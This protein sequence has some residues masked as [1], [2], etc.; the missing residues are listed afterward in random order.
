MRLDRP[1]SFS[2]SRFITLQMLMKSQR[3]CTAD[4]LL[5]D[6]NWRQF[7]CGVRG[8]NGK[9]QQVEVLVAKTNHTAYRRA[10]PVALAGSVCCG[11]L[12]LNNPNIGRA[13]VGETSKAAPPIR[14]CSG[15]VALLAVHRLTPHLP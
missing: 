13:R 11:L 9:H 7:P 2:S 8:H 14:Y 3:S 1:C 4:T 10:R 15:T 12:A 6:A 5:L